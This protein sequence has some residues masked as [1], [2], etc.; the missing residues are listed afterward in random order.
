MKRLRDRNQAA[1]GGVTLTLLV[2]L[3]L[4]AFYSDKLPVIGNNST[5]YS[6]YFS[7]SAGLAASDDVQVAGVNVGEVERVEL[8]GDQVLVDFTV[9]DVQLGDRTR[10]SIQVKTLLGEKSLALEPAGTEEQD[11]G[12]P[13]PRERT[14]T[15]F[16]VSDA[17][18]ELSNTADE[19]DTTQL[20]Q[21][22]QVIATE[23][24]KTP[25]HLRDALGGLSALSKT[26]SSRDAELAHLLGN[27]SKFSTILADRDKEVR[28][29]L[30]D[31]NLLLSELQ[32][33]K[34]AIDALLDGTRRLSDQLRGLVADN[35]A[36]LRPALT[37]LD[38][39]TTMLQRNQDNLSRGLAALAPFV[40]IST[41]TTGSGRW[42]E[43]YICGFLPPFVDLGEI[44]LSPGGCQPPLA[45]PP[46]GQGGGR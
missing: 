16:D 29:L 7:D 41:N 22:F 9:R 15:P 46:I 40:R 18:G 38:R 21:S 23:L 30:G 6:A 36:T 14:T 17:L 35:R 28:R 10:V 1:V 42:F 33:R 26:I 11:S 45:S 12:T 39:V 34:A 13:I 44:Q 2:L 43:G 32:R 8:D 20:A 3:V 31:G 4:A 5:T 19:I 27:T 37:E 25:P 24:E